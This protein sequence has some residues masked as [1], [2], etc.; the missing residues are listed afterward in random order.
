M[1]EISANSCPPWRSHHIYNLNSQN[2]DLICVLQL[3]DESEL[4]QLDTP[5]WRGHFRTCSE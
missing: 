3:G 5:F 2:N 1:Q 4:G